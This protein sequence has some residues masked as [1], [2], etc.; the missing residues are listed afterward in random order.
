MNSPFDLTTIGSTAEVYRAFEPY[1]ARGLTLGRISV[2]H[3]DQYRLYTTAGEARAEAIG[4]LLYRAQNAS[5]LP[6]VGDWV[7]AQPVAAGEPPVHAAPPR[8]TM[9]SRPAARR[10]GPAPRTCGQP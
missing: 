10:P 5:E 2:V 9:L 7:A 1:A 3:R 4:A 8:R 6:A